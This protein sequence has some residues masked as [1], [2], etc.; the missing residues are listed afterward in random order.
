MVLTTTHYARYDVTSEKNK[1]KSL[2]YR[3]NKAL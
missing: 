3:M 2:E 1:T